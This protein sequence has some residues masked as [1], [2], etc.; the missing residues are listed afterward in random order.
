MTYLS[1]LSKYCKITILNK[2]VRLFGVVHY[3]EELETPKCSE[4]NESF[5][6]FLDFF[7]LKLLESQESSK[8]LDIYLEFPKTKIVNIF[9]HLSDQDV[10]KQIYKLDF[11]AYEKNIRTHF[12]DIRSYVDSEKTIVIE[13]VFTD[14]LIS[15]F[16][17]FSE[18]SFGDILSVLQSL[19]N[20][21]FAKI[22]NSQSDQFFDNFVNFDPIFKNIFDK[23]FNKIRNQIIKL[24]KLNIVVNDANNLKFSLTNM[25]SILIK[26]NMELILTNF[27]SP[28]YNTVS[29]MILEIFTWYADFYVILKLIRNIA[30]SEVSDGAMY[31]AGINHI[32]N[33]DKILSYLSINNSVIKVLFRNES[34]KNCTKIE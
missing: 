7:K 34:D 19:I 29:D 15:Y 5:L 8:I 11:R 13:D 17:S 25:I 3:F 23:T 30:L 12:S 20:F 26:Q 2:S 1:D 10:L 31:I 27:K 32:N 33:V 14:Y 24:E 6:A 21:L 18:I 16:K 9:D 22:Y 4:I 28:D